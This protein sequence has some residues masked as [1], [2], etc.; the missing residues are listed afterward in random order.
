[1][2]D[3]AHSATGMP[4]LA[5]D[6]HL[7]ISVPGIWYQMGLH[8]TVVNEVCPFDVTG[9]T[10]SGMPGVVIGH[11]ADIAWGFTNL[12]PDVTDLYLEKIQGQ[13][14]L[15]GGKWHPLTLRDETI[16]VANGDDVTFTVRSTGHGPLLSDVS[17]ELSTVGA[18]T[19]VSPGSP[20]R[21][22]GYG[23]SLAWTGLIP[24]KTADAIFEV[25]QAEDWAGFR[26]AA[27]DFAVPAQNMV[28]AD[29]HGNIGYQAPGMIPIRQRGDTGR[30]P[31]PGWDP[32]NDWT[33]RFI[34]FDA[35]PSVLNPPQGYIV[36]ANQAVIGPQYK[37]FLTS[38]W[39]YGYR[40]QRIN[41]L[42]SAKQTFT[43]DDF[44]TMQFDQLNNIA[45]TLLPYLLDVKLPPGYYSQGQ[46][47]LRSWD[48]Q[49]TADS[50]A[51][52]YFNVVWSR[53]LTDTFDDQLPQALWPDGGSRWYAVMSRLLLQ[54]DSSWWDDANTT[55][56]VETRDDMI[57]RAMT[58][59]RDELTRRQSEDPS[60]WSW[61]GL[62]VLNLQS[63]PLGTQGIGPVD[64]LLNRGGYRV[65]GGESTVDATGWTVGKGYQVD[66]A[67]SMR[68]VV[69]LGNLDD[70]RWV[71]LTGTSGHTFSS[72]YV[73]QTA[74]WAS[75]QTLPWAFSQGSVESAGTS[76]LT[77]DP[78]R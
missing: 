57:V 16:K 13:S 60:G 72:N 64:W 63:Q 23:V 28:Y 29:V 66:W 2:V 20:L 43:V 32:G 40:S 1:V 3:G 78:S 25:D 4:L 48:G 27:S 35:L 51:A 70:S 77:L 47:L 54:P 22:N 44:T 31:V 6:P 71:N 11:N 10:F 61:G 21:D 17:A 58:E 5:N 14:Y 53:L 62:H 19:P 76:V 39:D 30:V 38:D 33:G 36:T 65:G 55:E 46:R 8:C 42:I 41:D 50:A 12:G 75:G 59:A 67:P 73:D 69:S 52:A 15:Y 34:P 49:Q 7:G 37:Y 68:M 9:Y 45:S 26:K 18:D 24:G 56:V 74:L